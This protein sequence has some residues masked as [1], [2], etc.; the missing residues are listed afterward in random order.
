MASNTKTQLIIEGQDDTQ[1][2]FGSVDKSLKGMSATAIKAGAALAGAFAIV[3]AGVIA[4]MVR[5]SAAAADQMRKLAQGAGVL[6]EK[7]SGLAWGASQSGVDLNGL[8]KA[9]ASTNKAAKESLDGAGAGGDALKSLGISAENAGGELKTA[10]QILLEVADVFASM[11]DGITKSGIAIDLFGKNLG[12][13]MI[14]FLN[15]GS[16]GIAELTAQAERLGLVISDEQAA[17]SERFN[18]QLAV[19]GEVSTGV[20]NKITNELLD[21]LNDFTGLLQDIATDGESVTA[22]AQSLSG[23]LKVLAVVAIAVGSAFQTAGA[24]I[25]AFAAS[26]TMLVSGDFKGAANT[27]KAGMSDYVESVD[28]AFTRVGKIIDG[29]YQEQSEQASDKN[30]KEKDLLRESLETQEKYATDLKVVRDQLIKDA[31]KHIKDLAKA[32]SKALTDI[33]TAKNQQLETEK[34][35]KEALAEL[36]G[37]GVGDGTYSDASALKAQSRQQLQS[38]DIGGAK[39]SAQAALEILRKIKAEGG[40]TYGFEGFAEELQAIENAADQINL[41]GAQAE[42]EKIQAGIAQTK[43][44]AEQLKDMPITVLVDSESLEAAKTQLQTFAESFNTT[45]TIPFRVAPPA[46]SSDDVPGFASGGHI[47][48]AGTGTSDSILA[49]LSNGEYVMKAAAV[50]KYGVR[51]M[52]NLNNMQLPRFNTGGMVGQVSSVAQQNIGTVQFNL[53]S[54]DSFSVDVAGTSNLDDLHRAA[55]KFGRTRS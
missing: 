37:G 29:S 47:R 42:F 41:D 27:L 14:P 12:T 34:R 4:K 55:L 48:G 6:T 36:S 51:A 35:Y 13:K 50:R 53:P 28:K 32:E 31:E 40:N 52:Q 44:E 54:G 2:A 8:S 17:K 23:A 20:G 25:G 30:R 46:G 38:G 24:L 18:D 10:D 16:S 7:F 5:D 19:L 33:K 9:L 1:K 22:I 3:T 26:M 43:L 39:E 49:R 21:P 15:A 45:I 11:P